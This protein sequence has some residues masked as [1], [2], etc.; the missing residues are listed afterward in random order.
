MLDS[1]VRVSR[2]VGWTTDRFAT[3]HRAQPTHPGPVRTTRLAATAPERQYPQGE[4][5]TQG[6]ERRAAGRSSVSRRPA[7]RR[8]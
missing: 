5:C 6:Q 1:L 7:F 4:T 8:L 3:D 2:R